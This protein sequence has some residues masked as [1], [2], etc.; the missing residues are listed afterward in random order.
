MR[1]R[2]E[3]T[4]ND[5]SKTAKITVLDVSF[6]VNSCLNRN[7]LHLLTLSKSVAWNDTNNSCNINTSTNYSGGVALKSVAINTHQYQ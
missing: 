4:A 2:H 6:A 3:S 7:F 5:T 1:F